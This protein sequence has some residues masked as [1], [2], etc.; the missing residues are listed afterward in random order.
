M[1]KQFYLIIFTL[2]ALSSCSEDGNQN[3]E[4]LK[5][6]N[7]ENVNYRISSLER[8]QSFQTTEILSPLFFEFGINKILVEN[9]SDGRKQVS[10]VSTESNFRN[11]RYSSFINEEFIIHNNL[12]YESTSPLN[13]LKL[14]D[15]N[16]LYKDGAN[17]EFINIDLITENDNVSLLKLLFLFNEIQILDENKKGYNDYVSVYSGRGGCHWSNQVIA[18][19]FSFTQAGAVSDLQWTL[20]NEVNHFGCRQIN[21]QAEVTNWGGFYTATITFCCGGGGAGG[22]W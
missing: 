8:L 16:L 18:Y 17:N 14:V 19:G 7:S 2:L 13:I 5:K 21:S 3:S 20:N 9:L 15:S 1:R 6:E 4:T 11:N 12:I 22:S 10:F